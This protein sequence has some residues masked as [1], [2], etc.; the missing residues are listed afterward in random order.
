MK[1]GPYLRSPAEGKGRKLPRK[2][3]GRNMNCPL[4]PFEK[5]KGCATL[6]FLWW[7]RKAVKKGNT[8]AP[9]S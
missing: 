7:K 8:L 2:K 6:S 1:E 5:G 4:L 9:S 3:I